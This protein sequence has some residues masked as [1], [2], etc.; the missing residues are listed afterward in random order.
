M[1]K[2]NNMRPSLKGRAAS[3][4]DW[5]DTK[6]RGEREGHIHAGE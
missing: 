1:E 2:N 5:M 3:L 4:K 6:V